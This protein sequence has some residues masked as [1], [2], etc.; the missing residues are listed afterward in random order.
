MKEI[1][2]TK[3]DLS[4]WLLCF[5]R[6]S[7]GRHTYITSVCCND[8]M[9]YWEVMS[10]GYR[11]QIIGDLDHYFECGLEGEHDCD[12]QSWEKLLEFAKK[13]LEQ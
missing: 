10:E 2:V 12:I 4:G 3:K 9:K 8:L 7:L 11:K 1:T 13:N 5:F 6:Y